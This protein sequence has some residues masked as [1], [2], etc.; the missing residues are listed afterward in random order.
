MFNLQAETIATVEVAAGD[1]TCTLEKTATNHVSKVPDC[2]FPRGIYLLPK[3]ILIFKKFLVKSKSM[4]LSLKM[5]ILS[6]P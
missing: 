1:D 2:F 3:S 5:T 4:H 6:K